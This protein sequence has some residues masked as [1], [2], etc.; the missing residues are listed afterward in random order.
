MS[1][2]SSDLPS[3]ANHVFVDFENVPKVDLNLF[4][5]KAANFTLLLGP[6]QTRLDVSLV[7]KLLA[8]AASVQLVRLASGGR[9][10]LDFA[11]VYYVG[12]AV[13]VDPAGHFHIISKDTGYDPLIKHLQSR[14]IHVQRH[15]SF[16]TLPFASSAGKPVLNP[17]TAPKPKPSAK[18]KA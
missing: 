5:S 18:S 12:R 9:N 6:R 2:A 7:E 10:A 14:N 17:L 1:T 16:A 3:P 15:D 4:D 8:N 13:V 11:L